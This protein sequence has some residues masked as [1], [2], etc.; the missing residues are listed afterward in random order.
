[1]S[2]RITL[3]NVNIDRARFEVRIADQR[4]E[5]TY[6]EFELLYHLARNAGKVVTRPRLLAAVWGEAQGSRDR[7]LTVH[8]SRLRKKMRASQPWM[9]ETVTKRGYALVADEAPAT[10]GNGRD[11]GPMALARVTG[12]KP[13]EA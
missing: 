12:A 10:R 3:G 6:V 7:K 9:I 1:M 4:V 5:L 13:M 11:P 8:L 2:S